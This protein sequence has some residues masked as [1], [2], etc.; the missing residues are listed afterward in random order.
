MGWLLEQEDTEVWGKLPYYRT[1]FLALTKCQ[2][3]LGELTLHV[4]MDQL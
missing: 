2:R 3:L 1:T 4:I